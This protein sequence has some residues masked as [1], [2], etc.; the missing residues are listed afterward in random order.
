M[1]AL[2]WG[3]AVVLYKKSIGSVQPFALNLFK[4]ALGLALLLTTVLVLGQAKTV[5]ASAK[6][7]FII[8]ISGAIGI[9]VSDTLLFMALDEL[10]ASRTALIDCLYSPL[11]IIFSMFYLHESLPPTA[12][13]GGILVLGSVLLSSQRSFGEPITRKRFWVG[14]TLGVLA[15]LTVAFAIVFVKPVLNG[16]PLI[17]LSAIRMSGGLAFLLLVMPFHPDRKSVYAVFTP[18]PAWKWMIVGTFFGSYLSVVSWVAGFKYS[19]AGIAALLN[20]TSTVFI[21]VF[22]AMFLDEP[23]N[24]HKLLAVAMAFAGVVIIL[25]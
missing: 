12:A 5:T 11:V 1:T 2:L 4:N 15:M 22:A 18:Q 14:C 24:R 9:G 17:W 23:M 7:L 16:Y 3:A 20:Q 25:Y 10:G 13:A 21:V 19:Q 6:D 8:L